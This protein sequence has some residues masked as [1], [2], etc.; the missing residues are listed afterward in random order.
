[1]FQSR[2]FAIALAPIAL[3]SLSGCGINSVPTAEEEAK[4][5]RKSVV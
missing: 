5:D 3:L 1:M 4:A 2:R